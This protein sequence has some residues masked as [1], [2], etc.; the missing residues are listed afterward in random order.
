MKINTV[1]FMVGHKAPSLTENSEAQRWR[2]TFFLY[3][4]FPVYVTKFSNHFSSQSTKVSSSASLYM[5]FLR[6]DVPKEELSAIKSLNG[7]KLPTGIWSEVLVS[8]VTT[9]HAHVWP[10]SLVGCRSQAASLKGRVLEGKCAS[11]SET[12]TSS[13]FVEQQ[14]YNNFKN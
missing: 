4:C 1:S 5:W 13:S 9:T 11:A 12:Q 7:S 2:T 6:V 14:W 3:I 8:H 10:H